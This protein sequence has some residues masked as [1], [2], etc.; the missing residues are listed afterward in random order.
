MPALARARRAAPWLSATVLIALVLVVVCGSA[1]V[2]Y[3]DHDLLFALVWGNELTGGQLPTYEGPYSPT[4][5][6][7]S[8]A[9][10]EVFVSFANETVTGRVT[11]L[12][13][14]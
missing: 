3:I 7:L 14:A 11:P 13:I 10:G 1:S 12:R 5:H 9:V 8:V 6:P 4:P 2:T